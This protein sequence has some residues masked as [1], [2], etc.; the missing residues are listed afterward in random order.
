MKDQLRPA[1]VGVI[2]S[3]DRLPSLTGLRFWAALLVVLYHLS[4][5]VGH[6]NPVTAVVAYGRTGVTFFFV[7]SGFVLTWTYEGQMV[8]TS[9]FL[10]RRFAR[11][12]PLVVV[13]GV[14]SLAVDA[15]LGRH[16]IPVVATSTF[17]FLQA[18]QQRWAQGANPAAWSLSDEALFYLIF[19]ALLHLLA[20]QRPRR[21]VGVLLVVMVG[22]WI[23]HSL[24]GLSGFYLDYFPPTRSL[25]FVL[26]IL[27]AMAMRRGWRPRADFRLAVV[28]VL[29]YHLG[30]NGWASLVGASG[31]WGAFVFSQW[32]A[33]PVFAL[34]ITAAAQRDL[35]GHSTAVSKPWAIRLGHWSFAWYLVHEIIIRAYVHLM[36]RPSTAPAVVL[37]W[38]GVVV[39]S[40]LLAGCLYQLVENPA[41]RWLRRHPPGRRAEPQPAADRVV[42][43][44]ANST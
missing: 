44:R 7:L 39:A 24:V 25:Q 30:L 32:F 3:R 4:Y 13:T 33:A 14:I 19:P 22:V 10:W 8:S 16:L 35:D 11:L 23:T 18:W 28:I 41:E 42:N 5:L 26:G 17:T 27:C 6:L 1:A 21:A 36:E 34:L 2:L 37:V 15:A 31:P 43:N 9:T 12:Y 40:L 38:V 29:A 20:K